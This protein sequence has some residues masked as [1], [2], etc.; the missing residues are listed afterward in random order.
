MIPILT[1]F[2]LA[3]TPSVLAS[4]N[5]TTCPSNLLVTIFKYIAPGGNLG[6]DHGAPNVPQGKAKNG[7]PKV[8]VQCLL[9]TFYR[10]H[11]L[12]G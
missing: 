10:A 1:G 5:D 9:S 2:V 3:L 11:S 12:K 8:R 7:Q 6:K 4:G